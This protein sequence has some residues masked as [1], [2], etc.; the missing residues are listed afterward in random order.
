MKGKDWEG[1]KAGKWRSGTKWDGERW[2]GCE[3]KVKGS[4]WDHQEPQGWRDKSDDG[5]KEGVESMQG[6]FSEQQWGR[7]WGKHQ[8]TE[9]VRGKR[10][11]N[12]EWVR[13]TQ[14]P[15]P[16]DHQHS[17]LS[18]VCWKDHLL[19]RAL[20]VRALLVKCGPVPIY[21]FQLFCGL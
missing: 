12:E 16:A 5:T 15:Q 3:L 6:H 9:G 17:Q 20:L 18:R 8:E 10:T 14:Y 11:E 7:R 19:P 13:S 21:C 4:W 1:W 2:V